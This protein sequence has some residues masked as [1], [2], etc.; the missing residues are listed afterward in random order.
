MNDM[1][2]VIKPVEDSIAFPI[3]EWAY[4][5]EVHHV[6]TTNS[7]FVPSTKGL[8]S[9]LEQDIDLKVKSKAIH[10]DSLVPCSNNTRC[11]VPNGVDAIETS[12]S[13]LLQSVLPVKQTQENGDAPTSLQ[14]LLSHIHEEESGREQ[15][16]KLLPFS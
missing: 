2:A 3:I 7:D 14:L 4:D 12:M 10:L 15:L 13:M 1:I 11:S 16:G 5:D 8:D 9:R 6:V